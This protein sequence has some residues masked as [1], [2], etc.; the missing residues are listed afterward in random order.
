MTINLESRMHSIDTASKAVFGLELPLNNTTVWLQDR[1]SF[2]RERQTAMLNCVN[3]LRFASNHHITK[4]LDGIMEITGEHHVSWKEN[5]L[6]H[7]INIADRRYLCLS[8]KHIEEYE[9]LAHELGHAIHE[10]ER[11]IGNVESEHRMNMAKHMAKTNELFT[12]LRDNLIEQEKIST[13]VRIHSSL[14]GNVPF[15]ESLRTRMQAK[16]SYSERFKEKLGIF[17]AVQQKAVT[18]RLRREKVAQT[19]T[20]LIELAPEVDASF[21]QYLASKSTTLLQREGWATYFSMKV[22]DHIYRDNPK[23]LEVVDQMKSSLTAK[24]DEYGQGYRMMTAQP[25]IQAAKAMV[26]IK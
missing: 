15:Y 22:L 23:A 20:A 12:D 25:S 8:G 1:L 7:E 26:N 6:W 17:P 10:Q 9:V 3:T 14:G 18:E 5:Q 16:P 4:F 19:L 21:Q 2:R 11:T 24:D 13:A